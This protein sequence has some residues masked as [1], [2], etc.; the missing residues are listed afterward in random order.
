MIDLSLSRDGRRGV[1]VTDGNRVSRIQVGIDGALESEIAIDDEVLRQRSLVC[2]AIDPTGDRI[3]VGCRSGEIIFIS[4]SETRM[5]DGHADSVSDLSFIS[6][7]RLVSG[8]LDRTVRVWNVESTKELTGQSVCWHLA[9]VQ[10]VATVMRDGVLWIAS[11]TSDQED[12]S[13]SV[14]KWLP[15]R[16]TAELAGVFGQHVGPVSAVAMSDDARLVASGDRDGNVF[17]WKADAVTPVRYDAAIDRALAN[18]NQQSTQTTPSNAIRFVRL[19]DDRPPANERLVS[20]TNNGSPSPQ[21]RSTFTAHDDVIESIRFSRDGRSLVTASDD[22]TLKIWDVDRRQLETTL[23]GHGGW[24]TGADFIGDNDLTV[25]SVSGDASV[26]T[27]RPA[28]YRGESLGQTNDGEPAN[29]AKLTDRQAHAKEI[30]AARF[31]RDGTRLV[32]ASRDRTARVLAIDPDSL[33]FTTV[34]ELSDDEDDDEDGRGVSVKTRGILDEGTSYVAMSLECDDAGRRLYLGSADA[35]IR[36]WDVRRGV[37]IGR[38]SGTGLNET[39][40]VSDD[41]RLLLSGSSS[42]KA[43]AILWQLDASGRVPAKVL[44]RFKGHDQ[45]VTAMAISADGSTVF[46]G[47]R[48]GYGILWDAKTGN[49]VGESVE[50]VR[51]YRIN[52]AK[53]SAGGKTLFLA[54]DDDQVTAIDLASRSV[55]KRLAHGGVVTKLSIARDGQSVVSVSELSTE[56]RVTTT[57]TFW[58][59]STGGSIVLDRVVQKIDS[60]LESTDRTQSRITSARF[61]S[62]GDTIAVGFV[63]RDGVSTAN[64]FQTRLLGDKKT[65]SIPE[66]RTFEFPSRLG[67][68][69]MIVPLGDETIVTMNKNAAFQWNLETEELI[70]SFRSHTELTATGFSPDGKYVITASRGVKIWDSSTGQSITK[71]E[72]PH[73]GPTRTVAFAPMMTID[74][75]Y[76]FATGG[77]DGA[78]RIWRFN[79]NAQTIK[80]VKSYESDSSSRIRRVAFSPDAKRLLMVGGGGQV[81]IVR[82]NEA[83]PYWTRREESFGDLLCGGF[84]DG[85]DVIAVGAADGR[86]RLWTLDEDPRSQ[87]Q[88]IICEGHAD[89]VRDL[90]LV[91]EGEAMRVLTASADDSARVWDPKI[92]SLSAEDRRGREVVSLRRH[93]GDVTSVDVI[94]E[95]R[96]LMTAGADGKVILWPAEPLRQIEAENLFDAL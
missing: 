50:S 30:V 28:S 15:G 27:W 47:D 90:V 24:V 76:V 59:L 54:A 34:A 23:K 14:W 51:G 92:T 95:G 74:D 89:A 58:D 65:D 41:G 32:T 71:L 72:S 18:A 11:A 10:Q 55:V 83:K 60:D 5:L 91:G 75:E 66:S 13:V 44:H 40:A 8:S 57:A 17:V 45:A 6:D 86:I 4:E 35:T 63:G 87:T 38:V 56:K 77:D 36:V 96:L 42:P 94:D 48:D 31:S 1:I 52:A 53:F 12:G 29:A 84:S 88:P 20:T 37:E 67:I 22:Y 39:F 19:T 3:A 69:E 16:E 2:V 78:V 82:L 25:L 68:A 21:T 62:A 33:A 81:A 85:G 79:A 7:G 61:N 26:R 64:I 73:A 49:R 46:T 80:A 9:P 43:K 70:K 93:K